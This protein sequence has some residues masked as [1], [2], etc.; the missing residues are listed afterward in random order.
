[1]KIRVRA[2][3]NVIGLVRGDEAT[4]EVGPLVDGLISEGFLLWL[5]PPAPTFN[6][7]EVTPVV[8]ARRAGES[9]P[10]ARLASIFSELPPPFPLYDDESGDPG[11]FGVVG[12]PL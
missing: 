7:Y 11:E 8:Q 10:D 2:T 9:A 12:E 1:M 3:A 4:V 6:D 5:D